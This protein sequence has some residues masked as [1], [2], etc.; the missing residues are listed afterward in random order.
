MSLR[1]STEQLTDMIKAEAKR[2]GFHSCGMAEALPVDEHVA[3][4]YRL[5]IAESHH[6]D[7]A[8]LANNVEK[9]LNP[10][11]LMPETKTIICVALNY[12]PARH[13]DS[14]QYEIAAYA[15]GHDYHD[16]VKQRLRMLEQF[17]A[18]ACVDGEEK[19]VMRSFCDTAPVLERYWAQKAGL[20]WI[21]RNH[22]LIIPKAGSM[23]FLG[24]LFI[25]I[26][27]QYD[28]PIN[29]HCGNCDACTHAC[30]TGAICSATDSLF[31]AEM[32]ISYHTIENKGDIPESVACQMGNSIYGCDRCQ[33]ACP[34]NTLAKPTTEPLLMPDDSLS[35]M[36]DA[37]WENLTTEQYRQIFKGSAVKRAKYDK[38]MKNIGI[39]KTNTGRGNR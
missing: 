24:E 18:D 13:I 38:L 36:T 21:G 31:C 4:R 22:Q 33:A 11:L 1:F 3:E 30:P 16:I 35:C 23:F 39:A 27:L 10:L 29:A 28:K 34:H 5:W 37:D 6:A 20:G 12:T 32:C 25:S 9:R 14:S 15:Y 17:I 26:P 7:M 19:P 2:L 8:Y